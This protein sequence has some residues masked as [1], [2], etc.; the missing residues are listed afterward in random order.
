MDLEEQMEV[1]KTIEEARN[2]PKEVI[3][4]LP[5]SKKYQIARVRDNIELS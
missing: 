2:I 1:A 3:E 5:P 4:K